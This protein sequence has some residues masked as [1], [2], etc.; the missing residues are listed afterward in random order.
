MRAY[1]IIFSDPVTKLPVETFTSLNVDGT[2]N[3][4]A[5]NIEFDLPTAAYARPLSSGHLKIWGVSLPQMASANLFNGLEVAIYAGMHKGLPLANPKQYGLIIKGTVFQAFGNWIGTEQTLEFQ[6]VPY[7]GSSAPNYE[8]SLNISL[9]PLVKQPKIALNFSKG[10]PLLDVIKTVLTGVY[11]KQ[12]AINTNGVG[13]P[14]LLIKEPLYSTSMTLQQFAVLVERLSF[15]LHPETESGEPYGG[16]QIVASKG[17]IYVSD[18]ENAFVVT[19]IDR[20]VILINPTDLIGQPTWVGVRT[21]Q[22]MLVLRADISLGDVIQFPKVPTISSASSY[23][24]FRS[25]SIFNSNFRVL[26][27]DTSIRHIGN[28]RSPS[29]KSWVT[30]VNAVQMASTVN[31]QDLNILSVGGTA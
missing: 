30:V 1:K 29:A 10:T 3:P 11:G 13:A 27:A 7:T 21:I 26:G 25:G 19:P 28:F 20:E 23:S 15:S 14:P 16:Y 22:A 2:V 9:P 17:V 4:G 24:R 8:P 5:L 6:F 31:Y 12:Y 18:D